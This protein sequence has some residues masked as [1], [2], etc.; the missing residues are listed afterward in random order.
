MI[1]KW[2]SFPSGHTCIAIDMF[3]VETVETKQL[4]IQAFS[5]F[6]GDGCVEFFWNETNLAAESD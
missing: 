2:N 1:L 6:L 4:Q 3:I 5:S